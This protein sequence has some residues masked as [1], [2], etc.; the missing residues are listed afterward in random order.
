MSNRSLVEYIKL[1]YHIILKCHKKKSARS[2]APVLQTRVYTCIHVVK[3]TAKS[4]V[5][6]NIWSR[7]YALIPLCSNCDFYVNGKIFQC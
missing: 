7:T 6:D 1:D 2:P 3:Y 5:S 4:Y